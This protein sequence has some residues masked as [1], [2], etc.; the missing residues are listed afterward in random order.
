LCIQLVAGLSAVEGGQDAV[1]RALLFEHAMTSVDPYVMTVAEFTN[2]ISVLRNKPGQAGI[3]DEGL[4]VPKRLGAGG[5]IGGKVLSGDEFSL[6][7][8]R[9]PEEIL[10]VVYG[11]GNESIPGGF[12]QKGELMVALLN[13][14]C[15]QLPNALLAIRETARLDCM[16]LPHQ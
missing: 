13:L 15:N 10:R 4:V 5:R 2:R 7:Y 3:K 6:G 9:T 11:S 12:Y 8:A 1:I 14:I 16:M